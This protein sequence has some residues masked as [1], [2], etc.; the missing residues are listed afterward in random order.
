MTALDYLNEIINNRSALPYV[1]GSTTPR[2]R[3]ARYTSL[4]LQP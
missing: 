3:P 2:R 4:S 1:A